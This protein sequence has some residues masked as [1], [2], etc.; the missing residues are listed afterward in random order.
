MIFSSGLFWFLE[1]IF[2]CLALIG[3]RT[4]TQ[5]KGIPMPFWKWAV[6]ILWLIFLGF[7]IAFVGTSL[8]E[9]ESQAAIL[10]GIIFGLISVV[11]LLILWKIMGFTTKN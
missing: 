8:G 10:G 1:G 7:T 11:T 3:L 4:W 9:G 5:D 6:S 2:F